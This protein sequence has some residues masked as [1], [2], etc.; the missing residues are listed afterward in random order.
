VTESF[1]RYLRAKRT[2]DDRALDRRLVEMLREQ[3]AARAADSDGP[4]RV[5]EIGAGIGTM[6]TRFL[7][8][9]VLPAGEVHYTAVDIQSENVAHL[10]DHIRDWAVDRQMSI[11]D[12]P[13]VLKAENRRIEIETVQAEAVAHAAA[14]DGKYDLL[15]GAAL[16]DILDR[17]KLPTLLEPLAPGGLYYFPIT[18]DGATRFQPSHPADRAVEQH[19]HDHMD[20]KEGGDSRAGG[21]VLAHLQRLDSIT[22][23]GVAGSDWV[24]RPV[25]GS[26]PADE[27]YFLRYILD[28]I[29]DAVGE[30]TGSDFE[31]LDG[32]LARRR[33]QVAAAELLYHTHQLDFLGRVDS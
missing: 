29:E 32:W 7:E 14:A 17:Q 28:T 5:L 19:Y 4:L 33:A 8:W 13:L 20:A 18:F 6:L 9:D 23:S 11:G 15:I 2:V 24:V 12:S 10:P 22:L 27:A 26:Y 30:M 25:D 3:L 31:E 21:D 1:Q 16:L